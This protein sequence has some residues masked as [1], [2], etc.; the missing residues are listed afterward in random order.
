[1][2]EYRRA[3]LPGATRFFTLNMAERRGNRLLVEPIDALRTAFRAVRAR[4]PF[5]LDAVVILSDNLYCV[6]TLPPGD[7]DYSTRWSLI[8]G[9]FSRAIEKDCRARVRADSFAG[10]GSNVSI[11]DRSM[12]VFRSLPGGRT[13]YRRR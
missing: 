2:T 8:K 6:W 5:D 3:R 1:M 7:A 11:T 9:H 13:A 12:E 10:A 4:H